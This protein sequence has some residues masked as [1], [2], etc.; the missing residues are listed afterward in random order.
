MNKRTTILLA[1]LLPAPLVALNAASP[2]WQIGAFETDTAGFPAFRYHGVVL[3]AA[4]LEYRPHDDLIYPSVVRVA[5]RVANPLG[6]FYLYYAP[7]DAPGG[8]CLAYADKPEGPWREYTNNP[9]IS[10]EWSPHYKASHV[11]GP[12][13]IWSEDE[14]RWCLFFNIGPRLRNKIAL[15]VAGPF[16]TH[17]NEP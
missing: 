10:R 15:A 1:A 13:A 12:D 17:A 2:P 7:H 8:I 14:G 11:S 6:R 9:I 4:Q 5:G 16:R 3:E